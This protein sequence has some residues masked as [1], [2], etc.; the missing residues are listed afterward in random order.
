MPV[1]SV[2]EAFILGRNLALQQRAQQQRQQNQQAR[3]ELA[4]KQEERFKKTADASLSAQRAQLDFKKAQLRA[5]IEEQA[6]RREI[7]LEGISQAGE[8]FNFAGV[9][10]NQPIE[11]LSPEGVSPQVGPEIERLLGD[12]NISPD[13]FRAGEQIVQKRRE[14]ELREQFENT[15]VSPSVI[16]ADLRAQ[17]QGIKERDKRANKL[18]DDKRK[19][20]ERNKDKEFFLKLSNQLITERQE[21]ARKAKKSL[22][23]FGNI[24]GAGVNILY[25]TDDLQGSSEFKQSQI[26]QA[27]LVAPKLFEMAGIDY[28]NDKMWNTV[29][30][31]PIP[32]EQRQR[33]SDN[34]PSLF[35]LRRMDEI[36]SQGMEMGAFP[37]TIAGA[38]V[39]QK[40]EAIKNF[41][42]LSKISKEL[43]PLRGDA[44]QLV[45]GLGDPRP[46][47]IDV[48][49]VLTGLIQMGLT[50]NMVLQR[51]DFLDG[52]IQAQINTD[53][54]GIS[55]SQLQ[56]A[57]PELTTLNKF[58]FREKTQAPK[59]NV[60]DIDDALGLN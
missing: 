27:N 48:E 56:L 54:R 59:G 5:G 53:T 35:T 30:A 24:V 44:I 33:I 50:E 47:D 17:T 57:F 40:I 8:E 18:L 15:Q 7:P 43:E 42:G 29:G 14:R 25:G 51:S 46:S 12:V 32:P 21:A 45:K 4:K 28:K 55:P 36:I 9:N 22:G 26:N 3:L 20:A 52:R 16:A 11:V 13:N 38:S 49:A 58:K 19:R 1:N 2:T 10:L 34:I 31:V 23:E 37:E 6:F 39:K 41:L 60:E